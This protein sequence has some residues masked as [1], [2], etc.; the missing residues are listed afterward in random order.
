MSLLGCNRARSRLKE[1]RHSA[2]NPMAIRTKFALRKCASFI[3]KVRRLLG[4]EFRTMVH[5]LGFFWLLLNRLL[6][7]QTLNASAEKSG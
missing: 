2:D 3:I 5:T 1:S 7:Q 4:F 6:S